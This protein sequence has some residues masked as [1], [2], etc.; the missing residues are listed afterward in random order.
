[1]YMIVVCVL[2]RGGCCSYIISLKLC[3]CLFSMVLSL[4][5]SFIFP[6][7]SYLNESPVVCIIFV[8]RLN[9]FIRGMLDLLILLV[10]LSN[11]EL[12]SH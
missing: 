10:V 4:R 11:L 3:Y 12:C 1:M 7:L 8:H 6:P 2:G 9:C 5:S